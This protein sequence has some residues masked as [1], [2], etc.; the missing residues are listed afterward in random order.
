MVTMAQSAVNWR[1]TVTHVDRTH[2]LTDKGFT[3]H[4]H[5]GTDRG[6]CTT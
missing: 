3:S 2:S 6:L 4:D 5:E 1:N